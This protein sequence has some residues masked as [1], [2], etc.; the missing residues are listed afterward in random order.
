MDNVIVAEGSCK[1][2][3]PHLHLGRS[4]FAGCLAAILLVIACIGTARTE[5]GCPKGRLPNL[6]R[7]CAKVSAH[8]GLPLDPS[9]PMVFEAMQFTSNSI[10]VQ[11]TGTITADTPQAFQKFV[12]T[13]DAQM[14]R[15]IELHSA[16]GDVMAGMK[17]GEMIRSAGYSTSIGRSIPLEGGAMEYHAYKDAVCT[18]ACAYA[19]MGGLSRKYSQK[20]ILALPRLGVKGNSLAGA[21]PQT[22]S[23]TLASYIAKMG[24]DPDV[25]QAAAGAPANNINF[26]VPVALGRKTKII[27]EPSGETTF[28]IESVGGS[29]T[30]AFDFTR[31]GEHFSGQLR[32]ID[33]TS[34]LTIYDRDDAI[35]PSLQQLKDAP[36]TLLDGA[37]KQFEAT[38]TYAR[39]ADLGTM[40]FKIPD[41]TEAAF[42]GYGLRLEN[43][44]NPT[45]RDDMVSRI[46]WA[47]DVN[48]FGFQ[49]VAANAAE[50]L[51]S[52]LGPCLR[53]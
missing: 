43:I 51:P 44:S 37:G 53:K 4:G 12:K 27:F 36:A 29:A 13:Y 41:L 10:V 14:T 24:A 34:V 26:R 52:A 46:K 40:V 48:A 42:S 47:D 11:A 25:L 45:P 8:T 7:T 20:D 2:P 33:S 21:D 23:A 28:R 22:M 15:I 19:F 16:G 17:L 32:C 3:R 1:R 49:I 9:K 38:A 5:E 39:V 6:D 18:S 50:T 35:R 30:V 31:Q